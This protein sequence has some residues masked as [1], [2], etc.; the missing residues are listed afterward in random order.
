MRQILG[1]WP[2]LAALGVGDA[3][4]VTSGVWGGG[5]ERM[6]GRRRG[7]KGERR[8]TEERREREEGRKEE[9]GEGEEKGD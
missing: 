3:A 2:P 8:V 7:R 6:V 5:V 9:R 4:R 1:P